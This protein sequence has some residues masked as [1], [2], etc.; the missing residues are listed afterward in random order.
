MENHPP[1]GTV[2]VSRLPLFSMATRQWFDAENRRSNRIIQTFR[3]DNGLFTGKSA[4][5]RRVFTSKYM[6]F[7]VFLLFL[8][9]SNSRT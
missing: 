2:R 9:S 5:N 7:Y 1:I 6:F 8:P 3:K 4:G